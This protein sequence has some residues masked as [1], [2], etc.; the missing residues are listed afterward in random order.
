MLRFCSRTDDNCHSFGYACNCEQ[1]HIRHGSF[2]CSHYYRTNES[3]ANHKP[4]QDNTSSDF[5]YNDNTY[6]DICVNV[7]GVHYSLS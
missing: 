3:S 7:I 2:D 6:R 1:N 5:C 4:G